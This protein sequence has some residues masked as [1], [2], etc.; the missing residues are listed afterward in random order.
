LVY[1]FTDPLKSYLRRK[2]TNFGFI[3][4]NVEAV[5]WGVDLGCKRNG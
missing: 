4:L 3:L 2:N 5:A 1:T